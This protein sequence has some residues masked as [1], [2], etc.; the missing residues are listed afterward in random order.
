MTSS[1]SISKSRIK[2]SSVLYYGEFLDTTTQTTGGTSSDNLITFN[3]LDTASGISVSS[4][5]ITV[6]NTGAYYIN[7]IANCFLNGGGGGTLFTFWYNVNGTPASNSGF[8]YTLPVS[9]QNQIGT[10]ADIV[11]LNAGDIVTFHWWTS[12]NT[13]GQLK[14]VAAGTNPVRPASPSVK[15]TMFNVG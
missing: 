2:P 5:N 13:Y 14:A 4:G 12:T 8:T 9:G 10:L 15:L 1:V 3:T 6:A 7:L 11:N